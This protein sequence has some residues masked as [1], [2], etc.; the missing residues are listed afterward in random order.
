MK[1]GLFDDEYEKKRTIEYLFSK[2]LCNFA[3]I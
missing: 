3:Y 1:G 2:E